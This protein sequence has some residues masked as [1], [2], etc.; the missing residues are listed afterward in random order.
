MIPKEIYEH[1]T[2]ICNNGVVLTDENQT[3]LYVNDT[4]CTITGYSREEALGQTPRVLSSGMQSKE[5]YVK[6]WET[7]NSV[8]YFETVF[9]NKRKNGDSY[10]Q[11]SRIRKFCIDN[12]I[13]Y[14]GV[15]VSALEEMDNIGINTDALTGLPNRTIMQSAIQKCIDVSMVTGIRV[16]VLYIDL[17]RF[18][19]I[20][21]SLGH[22]TGDKFLFEIAS[23]LKNAI[24]KTDYMCRYGGDEF[25][26][27]S[28]GDCDSFEILAQKLISAL[29]AEICLDT[30]CIHSS[31]SIGISIYPDDASSVSDMLSNS[32]SA[33]HDAKNKGKNCFEVYKKSSTI[34]NSRKFE[35]EAVIRDALNDKKSASFSLVYQPQFCL[36]TGTINSVEVLCR[37]TDSKLGSIYPNEFIPIAEE[38]HLIVKLGNQIV[39]QCALIIKDCEYPIMFAFNISIFQLKFGNVLTHLENVIIEH[40][41][42]QNSFELELTESSVLDDSD[43]IISQIATIS[44]MGY[45][46]ALDDFGTGY[47]NIKNIKRMKLSRLKIDKFFIDTL[48]TDADILLVRSIITFGQSLG[49]KIVVE[50]VETLGQLRLMQECACDYVQGFYT[51]KPL[52]LQDLKILVQK[53]YN[54]E[55]ETKNLILE[56]WSKT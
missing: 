41:I 26:C 1:V 4:F 11:A 15:F 14:A 3:I 48:S 53:N 16:G 17:D 7:I 22:S 30:Y 5:F 47:S 44:Q 8:G 56:F 36:K 9:H 34:V 28:Y 31:C 55:C 24:R 35:V 33:M 18:K 42:P 20:N 21:D 39:S 19:Q 54:D 46:V 52:T 50:G 38:T 2:E 40:S 43:Y 23:R 32:D 13:Y 25:I 10:A 45:N 27:V 49:F 12:K 29:D 51:S 6:M 37:L